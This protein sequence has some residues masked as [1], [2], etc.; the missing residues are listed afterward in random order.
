MGQNKK[1]STEDQINITETTDYNIDPRAKATKEL[2]EDHPDEHVDIPYDPV[3]AS[4]ESPE[5][6]PEFTE[7][8][9]EYPI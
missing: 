9:N 1:Y 2:N 3:P 4:E 5:C 6:I 7:S 8:M